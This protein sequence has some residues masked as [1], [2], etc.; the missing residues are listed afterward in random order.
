MC[1]QAGVFDRF[2]KYS[3]ERPWLYAVYVVVLALPVVLIVFFCCSGSSKV[4]S[5]Q[6]AGDLLNKK[7]I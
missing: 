5:S 3:N 7:S 4:R 6:S 1:R 2:L